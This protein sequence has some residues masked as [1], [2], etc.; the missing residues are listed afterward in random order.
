M[1]SVAVVTGLPWEPTEDMARGMRTGVL[2]ERMGGDVVTAG[3]V[4]CGERPRVGQAEGSDDP[5]GDGLLPA[6][7]GGVG[8]DAA[9]QL[10]VGVGVEGLAR[11]AWGEAGRHLVAGDV[12]GV[13]EG[14]G[15][16]GFGDAA[17][18]G[19]AAGR[20]L[21]DVAGEAGG[22]GKSWR[23]VMRAR[24]RTGLYRRCCRRKAPTWKWARPSRA[25]W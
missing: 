5:L 16:V 20:L 23:T 25:T 10:V 14:P 9:E 21:I 1:P 8:D 11:G 17:D 24:R 2:P 19:T 13:F 18:E 4:R 12:E 7:P 3:D 6:H 15:A 22:V